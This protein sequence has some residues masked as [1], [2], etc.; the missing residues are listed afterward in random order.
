MNTYADQHAH[1]VTWMT[2]AERDAYDADNARLGRLWALSPADQRRALA[3]L[4]GW[5][6]EVFDQIMNYGE[7][8]TS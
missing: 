2:A 6:P 4:S 7:G 5:K 3:Y 8:V 1:D